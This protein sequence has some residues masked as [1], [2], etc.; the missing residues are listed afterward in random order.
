MIDSIEHWPLLIRVLRHPEIVELLDEASWGLLLRQA[1]AANVVG[2]TLS[3]IDASVPSSKWPS[4]AQQ[5]FLA[6]KNIANHRAHS[7]LWEVKGLSRTLA[8]AGVRPILLKGAAYVLNAYPFAAYRHFGDID[9]LVPRSKLGEVERLLTVSGWLDTKSAP[10]DQQYY[11]RWMHELPPMQH[12]H[13]G[14]SLDVHH[15]ILPLTARYKP[16]SGLLI[17]SVC[18]ASGLPCADVL[19]P[20]DMF[21]HAAAHLFS[22]GECDNALRNLLDLHDLLDLF[23]KQKAFC[24]RTLVD[25]SFELDLAFVLAWVCR[26]LDRIFGL[27]TAMEITHNLQKRAVATRSLSTW[28][29]LF[30]AT[31]LGFHPSFQPPLLSVARQSLYIRGHLQRMP[32]GLLMIHLARKAWHEYRGKTSRKQ[33]G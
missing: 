4:R 14:T 26:Y 21:L 16:D 22:E 32:A 10:Y 18:Q 24:V 29:W 20:E 7:L 33:T 19:S 6:E 2:R 5:T 12:L 13:R 15:A 1:R 3:A 23:L 27:T 8:R 28:D 25:R 17:D 11:R 31:F 9:I 30:D